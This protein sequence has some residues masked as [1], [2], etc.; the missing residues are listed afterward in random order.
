VDAS[1]R[2][3]YLFPRL[4]PSSASP[5][6]LRGEKDDD[7]VRVPHGMGAAEE[8]PS[9]K[10]RMDD[11]GNEKTP[12]CHDRSFDPFIHIPVPRKRGC[13]FA[14]LHGARK[15]IQCFSQQKDSLAV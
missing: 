15:R 3:L 14:F 4:R 6:G 8:Y 12:A 2:L 11:K 9:D 7:G 13:G 5:L 10:Q 1:R